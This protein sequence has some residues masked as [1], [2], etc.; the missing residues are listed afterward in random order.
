METKV[1]VHLNNK[2]S[3]ELSAKRLVIYQYTKIIEA[4]D[5]NQ[6]TYYLF[7]FKDNYLTGHKLKTIMMGS[8]LHKALTNGIEFDGDH[9]IT[10][11]LLENRKSF[12]INRPHLFLKKAEKSYSK[13]ELAFIYTI[14]DTILTKESVK[15][16]LKEMFYQYRRDGKLQAAYKLLLMYVDVDPSDPFGN[17]LKNSLQFQTYKEKYKNKDWLVQYDPDYLEKKAFS[18]L[19]DSSFYKHLL[20]MLEQQ[21]RY[22]DL[23][24]IR[25]KMLQYTSH[26]ENLIAIKE[27]I[28]TH[29]DE[30]NQ[31]NFLQYLARTNPNV[32]EFAQALLHAYTQA[33]AHDA[34]VKFVTEYR[35]NVTPAQKEAMKQSFLTASLDTFTPLFDSLHHCIIHFFQ[36][37]KSILE[38]IVTRCVSAFLQQYNLDSIKIWFTPFHEKGFHL[39]IE[40]KLD[41]MKQ[42]EDDPDQQLAL[43]ELY[44][45]F[46]QPEKSI[47][48]FKWEMELNP[49]N[50]IPVRKLIKLYQDLG[51]SE[52]AKAYQQLLVI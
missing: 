16:Y 14:L 18:Q 38:K 43:G 15:K 52:E 33:K 34:V 47:E 26:Q 2:Q 45:L 50:P 9:P 21:G 8:Y 36:D 12:I 10:T 17:D 41:L 51:N 46:Q 24:A 4:M 48:C 37:E 49:D 3:L 30:K 32:P 5:T 11:S 23:L 6:N 29:F 7:F 19:D 35:I 13:Q 44:L 20:S 31:L 22:M 25:T 39:A 1:D 42:Y 27:L 40:Q 28:A